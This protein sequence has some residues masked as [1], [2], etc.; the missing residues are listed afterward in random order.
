M[1]GWM[2]H[3]LNHPTVESETVKERDG[4]WRGDPP[5]GRKAASP[6][7]GKRGKRR[8]GGRKE[9]SSI[10]LSVFALRIIIIVE[11]VVNE[12]KRGQIIKEAGEWKEEEEGRVFAWGKKKQRR[13]RQPSKKF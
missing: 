6:K 1:D 7:S 2:R 12:N 10:Q 13:R 5:F 8:K 9:A 11:V 4:E 3:A